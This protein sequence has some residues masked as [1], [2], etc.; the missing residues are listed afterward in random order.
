MLRREIDLVPT[1]C[2]KYKPFFSRRY[3]S[4]GL[5]IGPFG[6]CQ[7]GVPFG[8]T[9]WVKNWLQI[10]G[11]VLKP[12]KECPNRPIFGFQCTRKEQSGDRFWNLFSELCTDPEKFFN[13]AFVYNYCPLAFMDGTGRNLTPADIKE[14]KN[15]E[16]ICDKYYHEVLKLLQPEVIVAVGDYMEKRTKAVFK[17]YEFTN[18]IKLFRMP[19]PSPRAVNNQNWSEKAKRFLE[20]H[21]LMEFIL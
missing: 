2:K 14:R 21:N 7:T 12:L 19:H 6:M 1:D 3:K 10:D 9:Y 18:S 5:V 11:E 16:L 4:W 13:C 17:V 15:L 20:Q 8:D